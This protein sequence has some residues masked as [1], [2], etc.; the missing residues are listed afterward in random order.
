MPRRL[1]ALVRKEL[2]QLRRD[3]VLLVLIAWLYT[4]EV[5]LCGYA[6]SF[7][8]N[9]AAVAIEDLD[10][11]PASR[12]LVDR[13]ERSR[14]FRVALSSRGS[15]DLE[16]LLDRDQ[17]IATIHI[18]PGWGDSLAEARP[19]AV[20]LLVDGTLSSTAA[21]TRSYLEA[22]IARHVAE[23]L[24]RA[25]GMPPQAIASPP[26][27]PII[28]NETR[29]W[30]NS[31][32]RTVYFM[33]LSMIA[34]SALMVGVIHPAASLVKE[35]ETGTLEQLLVTP[36]RPW[37]PVLAK[38]LVTLVA[39]M[40]GLSLSLATVWWFEVPVRG[41]L[42][43]FFAVSLAF[44]AASIGLGILIAVVSKN[45]Q[46]ALLLAFFGLIPV[47]FLSGTLVPI[48]S[49]PQPMRLAS[50][51][52]PLRYYMDCLLGI[53]LKGSGFAIL[54]PQIAAMGALGTVILG[55]GLL[56]LRRRILG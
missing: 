36:T 43:L 44:Q 46:Q 1:A 4:I 51:L 50:L 27:A 54:W 37:E 40:A 20:Q 11:T 35:R 29:V 2:Q 21:A 45:L 34:L 15:R 55:L 16:A 22:H 32:L 52:S 28:D 38:L 33:V 25:S 18:P 17:V 19:A 24:A 5:V 47:M 41:S 14:D 6:L 7:D 3:P 56:L 53:F 31:D 42:A 12:G 49:M 13:I 30:F 8:L 39:S 48:E 23:T 10:G 26:L 9:D